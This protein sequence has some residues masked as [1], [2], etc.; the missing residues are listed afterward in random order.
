M[1]I[2]NICHSDL[3]ALA[4]SWLKRPYSSGGH[5]CLV[6]I[7][8]PRA[9]DRGEMP[10]AIGF[11]AGHLAGSVVVE[12]KVSRSDFLADRKKPHRSGSEGMGTWR[13]YMAPEGIIEVQDLPERW[14]LL[15]VN[16]KGKITP[17]AGPARAALTRHHG[18]LLAEMEAFR[19]TAVNTSREQS[20]LVRLLGRVGDAEALN[21]RIRAALGEQQRL[22]NIVN[23][24]NHELRELRWR[25]TEARQLH[26]AANGAESH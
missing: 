12:V 20:L 1:K 16:S 4:V 26:A 18:N 6:A 21:K 15:V 13:Y 5:G 23:Q 11:R 24:Q 2:S 17:V 22:A 10:D 3:C 8:E 9:E 25:L 7:S 14:G 19:H